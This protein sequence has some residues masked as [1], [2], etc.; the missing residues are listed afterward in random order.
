MEG[1]LWL[2]PGVLMIMVIPL[3]FLSR[4][5]TTCIVGK[6]FQ[7]GRVTGLELELY[8]RQQL[9]LAICNTGQN[10]IR[11]MEMKI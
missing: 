1:T 11:V 6:T 3:S 7:E 4:S 10:V 2:L 9:V 8:L 5:S